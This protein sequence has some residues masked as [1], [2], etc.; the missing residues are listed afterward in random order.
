MDAEWLSE[1]AVKFP[2]NPVGPLD[3]SRNHLVGSGT[4]LGTA[5]QSSAVSRWRATI[6][7]ANRSS[8]IEPPASGRSVTIAHRST[9]VPFIDTSALEVI[10]RLPGWYGRY[11]HSPSMTFAHYDFKRGLS[12]HEHFHP[13][14]EVYEV[15]EGELEL[16][17][18]GVKQVARP[19]MV[20]I[21]PSNVRH[22]VKALT[23][24]R[25]IIVDYPLRREM[26]EKRS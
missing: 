17:I 18:D 8:S 1:R 14:E 6:I 12:I 21:V 26:G 23:D 24:G 22:S 2:H 16:T 15:I 10:E 19:G 13:Q 11:F 4:S 7:P 3:S 20:G 25:A 9:P 5:E